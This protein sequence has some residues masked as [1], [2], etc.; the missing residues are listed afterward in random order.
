M[1]NHFRDHSGGKQRRRAHAPCLRA[2]GMALLMVL[3]VVAVAAVLGY[4]M[5]ASSSL[6]SQV[7]GNIQR[8]SAAELLAE[9]GINLAMYYVQ[10]PTKAPPAWVPNGNPKPGDTILSATGVS[11]GNRADGTAV[12]GTFDF[13]VK[14]DPTVAGQYSI[15][16]IGHARPG[17]PVQANHTSSAVITITTIHLGVGSNGAV[18]LKNN[19]YTDSFYINS[20][21]PW[22]A[23]FGRANGTIVTNGFISLDNGSKI[24]GDATP[25]IGKTATG[26]TVT[27]SRS[28]LTTAISYPAPDGSSYALVNDNSQV[29]SYVNV[30]TGD[31]SINSGQTATFLG[32]NYYFQNFTMADNAQLNIKAPVTIYINKTLTIKG[33]FTLPYNLAAMIKFRVMT[34][35]PV[36]VDG[37]AFFY[38]DLYAPKSD[39]TIQGKSHVFGSVVGG[40]L[41]ID[42]GAV[43]WD[44]GL[45]TA[46]VAASGPIRIVSYKP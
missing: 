9:S 34:N 44:E 11:L 33:G 21:Q 7:A 28:P 43:H 8:A 42:G 41:T 22:D 6:Q 35:K 25:G 23:A 13:T 37:G 18:T 16:A 45:D 3:L 10:N 15:T 20:I 2:R 17:T 1:H 4:A 46:S 24:N 14:L 12:D 38:M 30:L 39:V 32:G 5:L 29:A 40:T 27:G 19:A 31:F 36:V 26:G